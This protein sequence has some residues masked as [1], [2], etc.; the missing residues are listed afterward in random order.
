VWRSRTWQQYYDET[1][2]FAKS[3]ISIGLQRFEGVG[4]LGSNA[5]EWLI[6][7]AGA[8]F[9]GAIPAG[10]YTTNGPDAC[11][12]ILEHCDAAI[13]VVDDESQLAKLLEVRHR[14]PRLKAIVVWQWR[15]G[16]KDGNGVYSW[17][18]FIRLGD[19]ISDDELQQRIGVQLP[20]HCATLI[21]TSGTTG[22]PKGVMLSHDN[23]T[24]TPRSAQQMLV[25]DANDH[26]VSY[27]PL[28][29][30]A[31]QMT[32]I[33]GPMAVGNTVWFAEPDALKGS[34][35]ETLRE[36]RPTRFMAVPRVWEKIEEKLR[37]V[38]AA[39]TGIK[40][41]I[42]E[43]AKDLGFRTQRSRYAV[44]SLD[45]VVVVI[46][47]VAHHCLT[48]IRALATECK[49]TPTYHGAIA[50]RTPLCSRTS[51]RPSASID[52]RRWPAAPLPSRSKRCI[53]L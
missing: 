44:G 16:S 30:I 20:G 38:G 34:L 53:T 32:D 51:R 49:A 37:E 9:A 13:A 27:L 10:I 50:W 8:I 33:H 23:L 6:A 12:Y 39:N 40:K 28:S 3:C 17:G 15:D 19:R 52:A 29:H 31:A 25:T 47:V 45:L 43:W 35:A 7:N 42:G 46:V 5:P 2:E 11:H 4:I 41:R 36:V 22:L 48:M 1:A 26:L 21:Y 18:S 14:L 24:W